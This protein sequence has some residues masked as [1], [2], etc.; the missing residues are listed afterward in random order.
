MKAIL[1]YIIGISIF[2]IVTM[3]LP[4]PEYA[5]VSPDANADWRF[6]T[7][8]HAF[9]YTTPLLLLHLRSNIKQLWIN[10]K[11]AINYFSVK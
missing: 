6:V 2:L 11:S 10:I 4:T 7:V 5:K 9:L 8:G 1:L 3:V